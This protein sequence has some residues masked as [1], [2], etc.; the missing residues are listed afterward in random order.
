MIDKTIDTEIPITADNL[1]PDWL[2][3]PTYMRQLRD[4]KEWASLY[5]CDPFPIA[6]SP[7]CS[8]RRVPP[9]RKP[10]PRLAF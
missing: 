7:T 4:R 3:L 2:A 9:S 6:P 8:A 1:P 10:A 5:L